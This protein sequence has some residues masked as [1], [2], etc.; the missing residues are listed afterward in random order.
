MRSTPSIVAAIAAACSLASFGSAH[1]AECVG[2]GTRTA[3]GVNASAFFEVKSGQSCRYA[4]SMEGLVKNSKVATAPKNGTVRMLNATSFEYKQKAGLQGPGHLCDPGDR[5]EPGLFW[6]IDPEH[7]RCGQLDG[8]RQ[9]ESSRLAAALRCRRG[10]CVPRARRAAD[11]DAALQPSN[12]VKP[13]TL[14][15]RLVLAKPALTRGCSA[16]QVQTLVVPR[17]TGSNS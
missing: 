16:A 3:F 4:F 17:Q 5:F 7:D 10:L 14:F 12:S 11:P 9:N 2:S 8:F 15:E 1:A 13:C 6:H